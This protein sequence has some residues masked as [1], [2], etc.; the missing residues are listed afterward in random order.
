MRIESIAAPRTDFG[1]PLSFHESSSKEQ[2]GHCQDSPRKLLC[3]FSSPVDGVARVEIVTE[4]ELTSATA[5]KGQECRRVAVLFC[6]AGEVDQSSGRLCVWRHD[7]RMQ[8]NPSTVGYGKIATLGL[9][10]NVV[11][12]AS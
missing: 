2:T 7:T 9:D 10:R 12:I 1:C 3:F 11:E 5:G 6:G 4:A 8:S